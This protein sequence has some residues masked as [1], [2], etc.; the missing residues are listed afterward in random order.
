MRVD[1][2]WT[3]WIDRT[4]H[5][6]RQGRWGVPRDCPYH[7]GVNSGELHQSGTAAGHGRE[8]SRWRRWPWAVL[9]IVAV[10]AA[11]YWVRLGS[12]GLSMSEGHRAIPG[13]EMARS[14]EWLVPRMFER[15][16][17]RKPPGM[18]WAIAA[19]AKVLG[20]T[21]FS[22]RAVSATAMTASALLV[23]FVTRRWF[24]SA[25]GLAAGLAQAL[26]PLWWSVGRSAEIEAL[27]N[28]LTQAA[29]LIIVD[30]M[31]R[32]RQESW[33]AASGGA[34][35]AT[36]TEKL[37]ITL[38]LAMCTAGALLVKG[39]ACAG[40][41]GAT[42]V[43]GLVVM[44]SARAVVRPVVVGGLLLGAAV[45]GAWV[46]LAERAVSA[47][48]ADPL[49]PVVRQSVGDFLFGPGWPAKLP[50]MPIVSLASV[51][52]AA[53][54][55]LFAFGRDARA[56]REAGER[57]RVSTDAARVLALGALL[58]VA[59]LTLAGVT[60]PRY[61][62][63]VLTL[64]PPMVGYVVWGARGGFGEKRARIARGLMLGG[65][66]RLGVVMAV[67]AVVGTQVMESNRAR[68]SGRDAGEKLG[69]VLAQR[70]TARGESTAE[71]WADY[72]I[73]ARP[74]VL[75][76][77]RRK[78]T[79]LG[80]GVRARWVALADTASTGASGVWLLVRSDE[81]GDEASTWRT[82]R[83]RAGEASVA[84]FGFELLSPS[85]QGGS[86]DQF[87]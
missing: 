57:A 79:D 22:A 40:A 75:E 56:E 17:V 37:V 7:G 50:L 16:Y 67:A 68:K 24:G 77:C 53:A 63:P 39:P 30:A 23:F 78:A 64:V 58:G 35:R 42:L 6:Q 59:V 14:G 10:C 26:T 48:P 32:W 84:K 38:G 54:A 1:G 20:Q 13:W 11:V 2:L 34:A 87:K 4:L 76:W 71:V 8:G 9:L 82:G 65:P 46:W 52:P 27:N 62:M 60:N 70:A 5:P 45:F 55:L 19:A 83:E 15:V 12:S 66:A 49:A 41:I 28:A 31:V 3:V 21:E 44:R 29:C 36:P 43:A 85:A 47:M 81:G 74:E 33:G 72:S 80:V 69:E 25:G 51:M 86:G 73:E 61:S 18:F